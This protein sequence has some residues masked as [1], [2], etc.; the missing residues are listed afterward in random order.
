M[1]QMK[2]LHEIIVNLSVLRFVISANAEAGLYDINR[3]CENLYRDI[4][5]VVFNRQYKNLNE[6]TENYPAIDL[7]DKSARI[8][9]Q[10]TSDKKRLKIQH[11]LDE[12]ESHSMWNDYDELYIFNILSKSD[13]KTSFYFDEQRQKLF[14]HSK[15]L[16]DSDDLL[17]VIKNLNADK[18]ER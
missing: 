3:A 17:N 8:A 12:F 1:L 5:N 7:G 18:L 9:V 13:H 10:I 2:Y 4:F 14:D 16:K 15:Y 11:T 6:E